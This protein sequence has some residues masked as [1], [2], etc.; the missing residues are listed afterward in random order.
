MAVNVFVTEPMS[1]RV[2]ASTGAPVATLLSPYPCARATCP[3]VT[4]ATEMPGIW[5]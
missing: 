2:S 3:S 1:N 4:I 5:S